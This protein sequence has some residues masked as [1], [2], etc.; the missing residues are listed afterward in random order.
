MVTGQVES[1]EVS[2]IYIDFLFIHFFFTVDFSV[3]LAN[4]L[5]I[6]KI[7]YKVK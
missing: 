3:L 2:N 6:I 7:I 5:L 1:A 4:L